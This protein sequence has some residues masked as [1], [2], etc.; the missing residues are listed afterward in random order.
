L[1]WW[2]PIKKM[3][4]PFCPF[5]FGFFPWHNKRRNVTE[6]SYYSSWRVFLY[7]DGG[8]F[9]QVSTW[10][11]SFSG[12][13][14]TL[15]VQLGWRLPRPWIIQRNISGGGAIILVLHKTQQSEITVSFGFSTRLKTTKL[16]AVLRRRFRTKLRNKIRF[17][18]KQQVKTGLLFGFYRNLQLL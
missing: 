4:N 10:C 11:S 9:T 18:V 3:W 6:I 2:K 12:L 8:S 13:I 14:T 17:R 1:T 5:L 16:L 7:F 15:T